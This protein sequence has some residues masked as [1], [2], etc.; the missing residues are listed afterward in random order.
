V[1]RAAA[2]CE[3]ELA[4]ELRSA[5][6]SPEEWRV[7]SVL[8]DSSGVSMTD[9]SR[10][11]VCAPPTATRIVERLVSRAWAYRR[12]DTAD[13]RRVMVHLS[14]RGRRSTESIREAEDTVQARL[15]NEF[16]R[17]RY[18]DL[19]ESLGRLEASKAASPAR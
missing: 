17:S 11:A 18:L 5:G 3:E 10:A 13:R 19:V 4:E 9:L 8:S 6:L 15:E 12:I 7:V 2:A 16:G 14:A 1:H